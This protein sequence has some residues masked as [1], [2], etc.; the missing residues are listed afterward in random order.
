M[1]DWSESA[2]ERFKQETEEM[3]L[4]KGDIEVIWEKLLD[5]IRKK[6]ITKKVKKD[7]KE[8]ERG[9]GMRNAE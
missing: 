4:G 2:R 1:A 8:R 5:K 7:K 6:I 9:G 3:E